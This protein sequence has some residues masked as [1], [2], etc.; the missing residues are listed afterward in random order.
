M[1]SYKDI[2]NKFLSKIEAIDL[3]QMREEDRAF[4]LY[5]WLDSA[6]AHI[7]AEQIQMQS[8][9]SQRN[10][11]MRRFMIDLKGHEIEAIALYM[12]GVWYED[13][14]NSLEHTNMFW[15]TTDEKWNNPKDHLKAVSDIQDKY[16]QK[17]RKM[18]R[19]YSYKAGLLSQE[20]S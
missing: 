15:G 13:R 18:F 10:D 5:N 20:K 17:G 9:L 7:S 1:T 8:D 19:N 14:V 3:A 2:Y 12:V 4:M 16:F 6:L 11:E